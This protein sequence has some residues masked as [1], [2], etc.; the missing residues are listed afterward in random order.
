MSRELVARGHEVTVLASR[1]DPDQPL[2][3]TVDGVRI[4]RVPAR[5]GFDRA[6]IMPTLIPTAAKLM[7]EHDVVHLHL[8]MA[9]AGVLSAL[10]R[11]LGCRV[12]VTHHSDLV[13]TTG[14]LEKFAA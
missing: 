14:P 2:D 6:V 1:H 5:A 7:R 10:G 11:A 9:E 8:P 3:E 4:V 12:I 13:L